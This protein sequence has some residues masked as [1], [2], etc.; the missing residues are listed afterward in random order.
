ML[1]YSTM[2]VNFNTILGNGTGEHVA[3]TIGGN[4]KFN[5]DNRYFLNFCAIRMSYCLNHSGCRITKN[6]NWEVVSGD[7][8][9]RG[10]RFWYI[11]RVK[12]LAMF[13][14]YKIGKVIDDNNI[15]GM[16]RKNPKKSDFINKKGILYFDM[17]GHSGYT[18]H[19]T[20]WDGSN[21][22]DACYFEYSAEATLW[23]LQ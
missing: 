12:D 11:F 4:T 7:K 8:D 16:K 14:E 20:L 13:I 15:I 22:S 23:F 9:S 10:N 18:G 21:C 2:L 1:N 5:I 3:N 6:G 17:P 19:F